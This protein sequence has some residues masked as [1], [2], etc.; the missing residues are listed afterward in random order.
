MNSSFARIFRVRVRLALRALVGAWKLWREPSLA[1]RTKHPLSVC[2]IF[3]EEAPF[4]DEWLIFHAGIGVG[5]FYL[6]NNF[7]TD[8]FREVLRPWQAAGIVT[9]IDWPVEKGQLSAYQDCLRRFKNR[10]RW[11]AFIDIDE[12][13]FAPQSRDILPVLSSCARQPGIEVWHVYF[14]TNG[15]V[16][17]PAAS[18]IESYTSCAPPTTS[19]VKTIANPR[20]VYKPGIHQFKYW[21]GNALDT[22]GQVPGPSAT[23]VFDRLRINHYWSRSFEDMQAKFRRGD[24]TLVEK[25]DY[26]WYLK[27]EAK[28]NG[29]TDL[30]ILPLARAIH[31]PRHETA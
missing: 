31:K 22:S 14:G 23:P 8:N 26:D 16:K 27:F 7:S 2:A 15:H 28:L 19:T 18:V 6:Y 25:H 10:S 30:A 29:S 21:T 3:R 5:H 13:L 24:A 4:L 17:R 1:R 20:L 11:I 12:F 9:L